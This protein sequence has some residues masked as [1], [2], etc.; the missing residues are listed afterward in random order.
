MKVVTQ[1]PK[2][3][4][5]AALATSAFVAVEPLDLKLL[6][7]SLLAPIGSIICDKNVGLQPAWWVVDACEFGVTAVKVA[8]TLSAS[9]V[10]SVHFCGNG[11]E[12]REIHITDDKHWMAFGVQMEP[13]AKVMATT[14]HQKF[15]LSGVAPNKATENIFKYSCR[16]GL[17]QLT[18]PQIKTLLKFLEVKFETF[19]TLEALA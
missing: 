5:Q 18:V 9:G 14:D 7:Q 16:G 4:D 2:K 6:W 3:Y 15:E 8:L 13:P 12:R 11:F 10:R 17:K 1:S 19:P